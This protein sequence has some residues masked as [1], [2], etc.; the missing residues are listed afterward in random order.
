MQILRTEPETGG[1]SRTPRDKIEPVFSESDEVEPDAALDASSSEGWE[2]SS[3]PAPGSPPT[4]QVQMEA[5]R[6]FVAAAEQLD[7]QAAAEQAGGDDDKGGIYSAFFGSGL[8]KIGEGD[9]GGDLNSTN[10]ARKVEAIRVQ[11]ENGPVPLPYGAT[12]LMPTIEYLDSHYLGEFAK[13]EDTGQ[14]VPVAQRPKR[15][16]SVWTDGAMRDAA[17]FG[18]R[19]AEDHGDKW[20]QEEWFIAVFGYGP[21]HDATLSQYKSIAAKHPNVH[22]YSFDGVTNPAEIAEDMTIAMLGHK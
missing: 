4:W 13:D 6:Q 20:P 17:A 9:D 15:A 3:S 19:L 18:K 11:G 12:V 22:V 2:G 8:Y 10:M 16:R 7:S 21:D 1:P 5:F 14:V